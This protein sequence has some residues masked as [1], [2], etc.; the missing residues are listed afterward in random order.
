MRIVENH[1]QTIGANVVNFCWDMVLDQPAQLSEDV[2]LEE[3]ADDG[4]DILVSDASKLRVN[5]IHHEEETKKVVAQDIDYLVAYTSEM[6][7]D[8]DHYEEDMEDVEDDAPETDI[9]DDYSE[10]DTEEEADDA[11]EIDADEYKDIDEETYETAEIETDKYISEED[12]GEEALYYRFHDF[13][14][15]VSDA[16]N[17]V[18]NKGCTKVLLDFHNLI[19][20][21]SVEPTDEAQHNSSLQQNADSRVCGKTRMIVEEHFA[22]KKGLDVEVTPAN[23]STTVSPGQSFIQM[24]PF[25]LKFN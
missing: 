8:E 1:V 24:K 17:T 20:S 25:S 19:H 4:I 23:A 2:V 10:E 22:K 14:V 18:Y 13:D 16:S 3:A 12:A 21:A 15:L 6:D 9:D 5:E 11:S 7:T